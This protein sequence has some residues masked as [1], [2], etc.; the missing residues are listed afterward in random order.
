MSHMKPISGQR[1]S[2]SIF[3]RT[4]IT[5]LMSLAA[6]FVHAK[7]YRFYDCDKLTSSQIN[8][9]EQDRYGLLWIGT[10]YGLNRFD[11]FLFDNMIHDKN[12]EGSLPGNIVVSMLCDNAGNLWIGTDA[13]LALY[14]YPTGLFKKIPADVRGGYFAV[15]QYVAHKMGSCWSEL[16]EKDSSSLTKRK[17]SL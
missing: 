6:I 3:K 11:G 8:C 1:K 17:T 15:I 5:I 9:I 16:P 13:G 2:A 10:E 12:S 7:S 14:D 4:V